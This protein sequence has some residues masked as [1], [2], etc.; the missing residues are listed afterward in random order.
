MTRSYSIGAAR[1]SGI[2]IPSAFGLTIATL[3]GLAVWPTVVDRLVDAERRAAAATLRLVAQSLEQTVERFDPIPSLIADRPVLLRLLRDPGNT[4]LGPF[5][6]ETLSQIA[7][8]VGAS[9]VYLLDMDGQVVAASD[10][11]G[12]NSSIGRDLA[13]RPD[14]RAAA[15]GGA[16]RFHG[17]DVDTDRRVLAFAGPVTEGIDVLGVV[18]VRNSASA[19]ETG[20]S[21]LSQSVAIVD[22]DGVVFLSSEADWV[23]RTLRPLASNDRI[24][25]AA[26]R[27]YPSERLEPLRLSR[28][29][30]LTEPTR[31]TIDDASTFT[32]ESRPLS[33]PGWQAIV[34]SPL[35][36]VQRQ[37]ALMVGVGVLAIWAL[38]LGA[39]IFLQRRARLA[40]RVAYEATLRDDLERRVLERT[41]ALGREVDERR[42]AEEKLRRTQAELVHAG[43]LA[44][45]GHMS[46][47]LS[48][49]IN[50]PL[51]AVKSYAENAA[52][53]LDR[54]RTDEARENVTLISQMADRMARISGYLRDF[55]RR[56][57][58]AL[59]AVPVSEVAERA[60]V[61]TG[62]RAQ[63][64]GVTIAFEPPSTELHA[65]AG[66]LRLEQVI[67]NLLSNALDAVASNE[68]PEVSME[69]AAAEDTVEVRVLDNGPGLAPDIDPFEP[70]FTTK[71]AGEGMGIG[72]SISYNIV[73]DFGGRIE[74]SNRPGGGAVFTVVLRLTEEK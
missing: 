24:R 40:E 51:G 47:A 26:G 56:P 41:E 16:A 52:Q 58:D 57:G 33:L 34:L 7:R 38:A 70:F 35:L 5:V 67:V 11:R 46:A 61:L 20:W 12:D 43:K 3:V 71:P 53:Y 69:V 48:H 73:E 10:Y 21:G 19:L 44:A 60:L 29:P 14:I 66:A 64:A 13:S 4:G 30:S 54:G 63:R 65:V 55:A 39:T 32:A 23:Y 42:A 27:G 2:W 28:L 18:V 68:M 1:R 37:A 15:R 22:G 17:I 49:E 50:Q 72:L 25:L 36:P 74:A 59:G 8:A 31:V 62:P 6:N 9:D 45:L